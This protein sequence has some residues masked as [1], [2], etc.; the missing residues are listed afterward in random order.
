MHFMQ[1]LTTQILQEFEKL[2]NTKG[3]DKHEVSESKI[4]GYT[5]GRQPYT[6]FNPL[7]SSIFSCISF[8][9]NTLS[10]L[11]SCLNI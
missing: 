11:N 2:L 6:T 8:A 10:P 3:V 9:K 4:K 5:S 1:N 7:S